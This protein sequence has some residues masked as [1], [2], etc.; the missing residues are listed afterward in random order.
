MLPKKGKKAENNY[1]SALD[2]NGNIIQGTEAVIETWRKAYE[3]LGND[4]GISNYDDD[5]KEQVETEFTTM[6][7]TSYKKQNINDL[8]KK[9]DFQEILN[10]KSQLSKGKAAGGDGIINELLIYGGNNILYVIWE[11]CNLCLEKENTPDEWMEGIMFP[12]YK[13]GDKRDPYNHRG[14]TLLSII[15]KFYEGLLNARLTKY[16]EKKRLLPEEQGGF[17]QN[18]GC[19]DQIYILQSI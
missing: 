12:I 17:R 14:I 18:R 1:M 4:D 8:S 3:V 10:I 2:L 15:S 9:F 5:F 16:C 7:A 11:L 19:V 6:K 13:K